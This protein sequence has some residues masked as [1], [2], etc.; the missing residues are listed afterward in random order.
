MA[1][2][3]EGFSLSHAAILDGTTGAEDVNGDIYGI[4]SGSLSVDTDT[5]DNTGDNAVLSTWSWFNTG[6]VT[7]QAGYIP[8]ETLKLITGA[9]IT[10]SGNQSTDG[11]KVEMLMWTEDSLNQTAKPMLIRMLSKD[12][13]LQVR[14]L[15]FIL[16]RVIFDPISFDGPAY[17]DGLL[18]TY[19]GR[20]VMSTTDEK[21]QPLPGGKKAIGRIVSTRGNK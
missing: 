9:D 14:T 21:G 4:R 1:T 11:S 15:E 8:F 12:R 6:T 16:F 18:L 17:R 3:V 10:S 13:D 2:T 7:V 5:Y 19:G 20:A